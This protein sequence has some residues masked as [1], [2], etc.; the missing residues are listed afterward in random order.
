[1]RKGLAQCVSRYL[2]DTNV[3]RPDLSNLGL[4]FPHTADGL[5][6]FEPPSTFAA[7]SAVAL[8][9]SLNPFASNPEKVATALHASRGHALGH[10]LKRDLVDGDGANQGL[11]GRRDNEKFAGPLIRPLLCRWQVPRQYRHSANSF[12][13]AR[14]SW[15][16]R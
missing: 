12:G 13:R 10:Q 8:G 9:G 6:Q 1:M 11:M 7:C 5:F 4:R 2:R 16:M 3:K 14:S 15:M